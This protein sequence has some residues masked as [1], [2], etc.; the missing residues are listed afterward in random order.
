MSAL[1][2]IWDGMKRFFIH[3]MGGLY[4]RADEHHIFLLAGGLAFSTFV[5]MAPLALIIFSFFGNFLEEHSIEAEINAAIDRVIPY[6]DYARFIQ[7]FIFRR[8]EEFKAGSDIAGYIGAVGLLLAASGLFSSIRTI[9][10]RIFIMEKGKSFFIGKLRDIGM[11]LIVIC[12]FLALTAILPA[13]EILRSA[14]D[15]TEILKF[16]RFGIRSSAMIAV[17]SYFLSFAL[18]YFIY[19][20][21]PYARLGWKIPALSAFW[22]AILW[23]AAKWAFGYYIAHLASF[24]QIYG[25][26]VFII[27]AAFW[28]YYSAIIFIIGAEIG[29]LFRE[30]AK[31]KLY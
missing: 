6:E 16:L 3:Y 21:V 30:R 13:F 22:A 18:F 17:F 27:V 31:G 25:A 1:A 26:Y 9:L 19:S 15:K 8:I 24:K 12:F 5:C 10:N 4:K 29:Q 14:A 23:E 11:V 28:I 7:D 20:L 2:K